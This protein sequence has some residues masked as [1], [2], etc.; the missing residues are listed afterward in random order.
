MRVVLCE[1]RGGVEAGCPGPHAWGCWRFRVH[2]HGLRVCSLQMVLVVPSAPRGDIPVSAGSRSK[3][4]ERQAVSGRAPTFS[5]SH[6]GPQRRQLCRRWLGEEAGGQSLWRLGA[7]ECL[8]SVP[9]HA[10]R[11]FSNVAGQPGRAG[12]LTYPKIT[13]NG[14]G[15]GQRMKTPA[16]LLPFRGTILR[17]SAVPP[18]VIG[19][20]EPPLPTVS[21]CS[22]CSSVAFAGSHPPG[23]TLT[24]THRPSQGSVPGGLPA[25]SRLASPLVGPSKGA[26]WAGSRVWFAELR[27][28]FAESHVWGAESR[29]RV[30]S[31][32]SGVPSRVSGAEHWR[33]T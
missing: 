11:C 31:R 13:L 9:T 12:T 17:G 23:L 1:R 22:D 30:P 32:V 24:S 25:P 6:S 18:R 4:N 28:W 16:S 29:V 21:T 33:A 20:A 14:L 3:R 2:G 10:S 8:P 19:G 26:R 15:R 5:A 27:V 7:L